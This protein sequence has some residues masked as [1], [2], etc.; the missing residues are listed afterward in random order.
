[1]AWRCEGPDP[2]MGKRASIAAREI[3]AGY[4]ALT[5]DKSLQKFDEKRT[6]S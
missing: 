5:I 1:M 2:S 3:P 6:W 4:S